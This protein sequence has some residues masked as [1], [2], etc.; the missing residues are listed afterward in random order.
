MKLGILGGTP[1]SKT[2]GKEYLHAGLEVVFG[3]RSDFEATDEEWKILNRLHNRICPFESAIIQAEIILICCESS[4]L[5]EICQALKN[6]ETESKL[7][8]DCTH[9]EF[10]KDQASKNSHSIR[11]SAPEASIFR[12]FNNLGTDY[13]SHLPKFKT[14]RET[15][16]FSNQD[17]Q[18]LR[19]KR[20]IELIGFK[21]KEAGKLPEG[22]K[23][24]TNLNLVKEING[25]KKV[26]PPV[27]LKQ[28]SV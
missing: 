16:L 24:E 10:D 13:D 7:I 5:P 23:L 4:Q 27:S 11:R 8:V 20:L 9:T 3:V 2:L 6:V 12:A 17:S 19:I 25:I 1:L 22:P 21:A 18:K 15:N 14:I 28:L 26:T